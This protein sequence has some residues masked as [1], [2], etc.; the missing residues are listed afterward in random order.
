MEAAPP[1]EPEAGTRIRR[2]T[3]AFFRAVLGLLA[4]GFSTYAVLYCTQPLLPLLA[5]D[6]NVSPAASS[7]SLSLATGTLA[8]AMLVAGPFSDARGRKGLMVV[9]LLGAALLTLLCGRLAD[10][11][12]ILVLRAVQG[13]VLAGVP[14]VAMAY[15]AEEIDPRAIGFAMG[16]YISGN[17]LGGMSGR[18]V[19]GMVA[20]L[21][22]W[23]QALMVTGLFAVA[24]A[25]VLWRVLPPSRHFVPRPLRL[26]TLPH[27]FA[28]P[29]RDP[30]LPWLYVLGFLLMGGFVTVYNYAPFRLL[31]PPYSLGQAA[32]G[33]I[34]AL[35]VLGMAS[36]A[37][38]G[39]LTTRVAY[40]HLM[41]G[42]ILLMLASL[43]LTLA[44]SLWLVIGGIALLTFGFFAAH[45]L[46][47]AWVGR[48]A[49]AGKGA[50]SA[51]YLLAYYAGSSLMG[52]VGGLF[53][54]SAG[55][56][57]LVGFTGLLVLA[58]LAA[59]VPLWRL[60]E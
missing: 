11:G 34:F 31:A 3:P 14:A 27:H 19:T 10:W 25:L 60:G 45:S 53:W 17:A 13:A 7:L 18:L 49:G 48:R 16:L 51:L 38:V 47:S 8:P 4:A 35:Y 5:A 6:F 40:R 21:L 22:S 12:A 43:L 58:G 37:V 30:G 26:A 20:E 29:L 2:G 41:L 32:V 46:A 56:A 9:S 54:G 44:T 57:G 28:P 33:A 1:I 42:A 15:V 55:W 59:S 36:S 52:S 24:C 23:R 50:A 39:M